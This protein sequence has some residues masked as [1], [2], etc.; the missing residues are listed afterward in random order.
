[1][2]A[3]NTYQHPA[4]WV[5]TP[6]LIN[7]RETEIYNLGKQKG[8]EEADEKF[9]KILTK[10]FQLSYKHTTELLK[11]LI[12][13]NIS[14]I[15]A[16]LKL[17]QI[18]DLKVAVIL[19]SDENVKNH[20]SEVYDFVYDLEGKNNKAN[21][22]IDFTIIKADDNFQER[23]VEKDGYIFTHQLLTNVRGRK[24]EATTRGEK[25]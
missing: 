5:T 13:K 22:N 12:K 15:N 1:M 2:I 6:S 9:D 11:F 18:N 3:E 4:E 21:Y 10:N 19:K 14:V 23:L 24:K 25:S 17:E 20:I 8:L 16:R 7:K